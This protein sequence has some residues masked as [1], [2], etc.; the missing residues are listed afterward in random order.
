MGF[1]LQL[2]AKTRIQGAN[3]EERHN[4]PNEDQVSHKSAR[5]PK[6]PDN[7]TLHDSL[8]SVKLSWAPNPLRIHK[9]RL[10]H[11]ENN[12]R[13]AAPARSLRAQPSSSATMAW[14]FSSGW[15]RLRS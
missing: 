11:G 4:D 2:V 7:Q 6:P 9:V 15:E 13:R 3:D 14:R 10:C 1:L 8:E 12:A 5:R